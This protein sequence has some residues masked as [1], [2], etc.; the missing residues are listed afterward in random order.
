MPLPLFRPS[1][2][3]VAQPRPSG[4]QQLATAIT[5]DL[6]EAYEKLLHPQLPLLDLSAFFTAFRRAQHNISL[7]SIE[8]RA[9]AS[10]M[11]AWGARFIDH[12]AVM[13]SHGKGAP[14]SLKDLL[15]PAT[16]EIA[17]AG[18]IRDKFATT[19]LEK[20]VQ[21][22]DE[23]ALWRKPSKQNCA[24]LLV[25][26]VLVSWTDEKRQAGRPLLSAAVEHLR[27]LYDTSLSSCPS[28]HDPSIESDP[29]FWCAWLRDAVSA[30]IGGRLPLLKEEDLAA[31]CPG[32]VDLRTDDLERYVLIN[33]EEPDGGRGMVA[34]FRH[35]TDVARAVARLNSPLPRRQPIDFDAIHQLWH[36]LSRS[37]SST[38]TFAA[39]FAP[40][41]EGS[42]PFIR[43]LR[44]CHAQISL[45]IHRHLENR[46]ERENVRLGLVDD[47][48]EEEY[49]EALQRLLGESHCAL[50]CAIQ[51]L[52]AHAKAY[53]THLVYSAVLITEELPLYLEYLI[54]L[55]C[56][57][58]GGTAWHVYEKQAALSWLESALKQCGWCW[59]VRPTLDAAT[60]AIANLRSLCPTLPDNQCSHFFLPSPTLSWASPPRRTGS[61]SLGPAPA[62]S[63]TTRSKT[64]ADAPESPV[65]DYT[66]PPVRSIPAGNFHPPPVVVVTGGG[67]GGRSRAVSSAS[68][69]ISALA[70]EPIEED[71][72]VE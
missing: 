49:I 18:M 16:E 37:I 62:S 72:Q 42:V 19:L 44:A 7:L 50:L 56:D 33:E 24:A 28:M 64:W 46:L 12:P 51:E 20:A 32:A 54:R 43:D 68:S 2:R 25:L 8:D 41:D 69:S 26:E 15:Q 40:S 5:I 38:T 11:H 48:D 31:I 58:E 70:L 39:S 14:P 35:L 53:D 4:T 65:D 61:F 66:V 34:L 55:P 29:S 9:I 13:G 27:T 52:I 17:E 36:E 47:E 45:A 71:V 22:V 1:L 60:S 21:A 10:I 30:A 67:T 3:Q 59:P 57:V 6:F 63:A 23:A